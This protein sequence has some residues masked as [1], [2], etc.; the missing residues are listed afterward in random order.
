MITFK[1]GYTIHCW[2][3]GMVCYSAWKDGKEI[4][5]GCSKTELIEAI[6]FDPDKE[7]EET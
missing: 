7:E 6:G 1:R 2:Y 3:A 5:C 4:Y